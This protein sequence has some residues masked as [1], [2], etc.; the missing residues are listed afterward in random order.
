MSATTSG[1]RLRVQV[2]AG[3]I[4]DFVDGK[5]IIVQAGQHSV[6][7]IRLGSGEWRAVRNWC[8]HKGAPICRGIV[9]GTWPPSAPGELRF[10]RD[11]EVLICPW[12]GFEFD[13]ENG[14]ELFREQPTKLRFFPVE[15]RDGT[16]Y[17]TV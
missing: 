17:V 6:G 5:F 8:P 14:R 10:E 3:K 4:E 12:H 9:G 7:V 11:G 15:V 13:L 1:A 2:V 16:V